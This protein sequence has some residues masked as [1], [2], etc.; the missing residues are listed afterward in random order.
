MKKFMAMITLLMCNLMSGSYLRTNDCP[1]NVTAFLDSSFPQCDLN[2]TICCF[3]S[4][5][6]VDTIQRY[7]TL[8]DCDAP[9][10]GGGGDGDKHMILKI[11]GITFA[12]FTFM[13]VV[14][15]EID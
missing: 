9:V 12:I 3:D 14:Y 5:G 7:I 6:D 13:A 10:C 1:H 11:F 4:P 15:S 2:Q 8:N